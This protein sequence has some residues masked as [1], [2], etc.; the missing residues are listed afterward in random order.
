MRLFQPTKTLTF[1]LV[2]LLSI[3]Q[4]PLAQMLA[5]V[6]PAM[7]RPAQPKKPPKSDLIAAAVNDLLKETPLHS[8]DEDV[9]EPADENSSDE[10]K[11]PADDAPIRELVAFWGSYNFSEN[12]D[13]APKPS[14]KVRERLLVA[15]ENR[16]WLASQVLRQL[17]Q[18]SDAYDRLYKLLSEEPDDGERSNWRHLIRH[19]LMLNS[20][21]FREELV[22]EARHQSRGNYMDGSSLRALAKLDWEAAKLFVED[23][24]R[25]PIPQQSVQAQAMIY[26]QAVRANDSSQAE[27]L[28]S[29]LKA[30]VANRSMGGERQTA[31][32]SLMETEWAG[33]EEWY[34][35]L[36][37]DASL[38]GALVEEKIAA[39]KPKSETKE[40]Q[41]KAAQPVPEEEEPAANILWVPML[42]AYEKLLPVVAGLIGDGN[43]TVHLAAVST[44]AAFLV[45]G[46]GKEE[47]RKQA[48]RALL[49]WL[50]Q[51]DWGGKFERWS[52][53]ESLSKLNLPESV[54][55]LIWVLDND[56]QAENRAIAAEAL[57]RY[58]NPQAI[59][60]LRR[61]LNRDAD[62]V[63]RE[64]VILAL[65]EL[66]GFP[67]AEAAAA[68]EAYARRSLTEDGE[69]EI[70]E[71]R[72]G[73]SEKPLPL[74][75]SIGAVFSESE[76]VEISDS[77]ATLLFNRAKALRKTQ[78]DLAR[79]LVSIAQQSNGIVADLNLA[80]RI[81]EG[82]VDVEA[83]KLALE[84]RAQLRKNVAANLEE[85]F[86][87]G[88][89]QTGLAAVILNEEDK[90]KS[91]L[92]GRDA[93]AQLALL[94][95]ARYAREKLPVESVGKLMANASLASAA[96]SYLEIEDSAEARRLV[97]ARHPGEARILGE[98]RGDG[99]N[100]SVIRTS[101]NSISISFA[102]P[103]LPPTLGKWE[104]KMRQEVL[105]PNGP[106]E[107]YA[108]TPGFNPGV[109]NS[110]I[111]RVGQGKA[112][113]SLHQAEGR[114]L[115]RALDS[116]ELQELKELTSRE[117]IE[118]L[119]PEKPVEQLPYI[120]DTRMPGYE[121]LRL[122]KDGG[123]RI[124]LSQLRREPKKEATLHEQLS[125][126]FYRLSKTGEY[127]L[128]YKME[129]LI[130]GV[131]VL[132][133]DD[134][135][136]VISV[137]QEAGQLRVMVAAESS[138]ANAGRNIAPE[139]LFEWRALVSGR[140]GAPSDEAPN[141][142]SG[143][144]LLNVPYWMHE[145]RLKTGLMT[146]RRAKLGETWFAQSNVEGDFGIWQYEDG[147]Q[148]VKIVAGY[149]SNLVVTPDGKWLV[150]QKTIES[151]EKYETRVVRIQLQT[152]RE[153]PVT[154]AQATELI[155]IS[156]VAA[157]NKLLLIQQ[158]YQYREDGKGNFFLLDAET[159]VAQPIKGEFRPLL[160][161]FVRP[162]QATEKPDEFW[163][164]IYDARKKATAIGRYDTR[165]FAFSPV[166][167]L[168]EIRLT[169]ADTWADAA[170]GK[171]YFAYLGHLLRVPL[172]AA[173]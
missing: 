120:H 149:Y 160:N 168:P 38:S 139:K 1:L 101:H 112:E 19:T 107:I 63:S 26:E 45:D 43:R 34:A 22:N 17:P 155:P 116:A 75:I 88:G 169:S 132:L 58:K 108:V 68:I 30:V 163:A 25:H 89:Y 83:V 137:C 8:A 67:D 113:I 110:V 148:P 103:D 102:D 144:H 3:P 77:L 121:Y 85:L 90:L 154:G 167:E 150:A 171:L 153:F 51:P 156:Y 131:E 125:G 140:L 37:A 173:K 32:S 105:R 138:S 151:E 76:E 57:I 12:D 65:I 127:K 141:C 80:D 28:R 114:R 35:S 36:F 128:R 15:V 18:T 23:L 48:A 41:A 66:G 52:Y 162:L 145:L 54:P 72:E 44:L 69:L 118:N 24:A 81:A 97:W 123:R 42:T 157:R 100:D 104:E 136:P 91:V 122:T 21:F 29:Q 71:A 152:K 53:L 126:F 99:F 95:A 135:R 93:L 130:P 47:L 40:P 62:E 166:L 5:Q 64:S 161:Q 92:A 39:E 134:K 115:F 2:I 10:W 7:R 170:A 79:K 11:P 133:A 50:S 59:P 159:G 61:A 56:E 55:G 14:D 20:S 87:Q 124:M 9:A 164:S 73:V 33:R 74:Q 60:A 117:E 146:D 78:P 96:E 70:H 106:S 158:Q 172:P 165:T 143:N 98:V 49:P 86:K 119:G 13:G 16:P 111:V 4:H 6:T 147:K 82:W 84:S 27:W 94:A 31:L 46:S 129:D 109:Y 142:Q